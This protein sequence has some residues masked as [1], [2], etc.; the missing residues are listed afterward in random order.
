MRRLLFIAIFSLIAVCAAQGDSWSYEPK[1]T[2]TVHEFGESRFVLAVDA[3]QKQGFP[4]HILSIYRDG[5][6]MARYRNVGF[7][8]IQPVER[9]E[10]FVGLSNRG[11]PGTAFVI[12]DAQGNLVREQ[13]HRFM[14]E[15]VYTRQSVTLI[16][17]WYDRDNPGLEVAFVSNELAV[18]VRGSNGKQY[19][20]M[21]PTLHYDEAARDKQMETLWRR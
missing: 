2:E 3:R 1:L 16:R 15:D 21:H 10:F 5:K 12:F 4:D 9:T 13:K 11:I 14:P 7:D 8:V 20:L 19:N 18:L 6:L 17:E